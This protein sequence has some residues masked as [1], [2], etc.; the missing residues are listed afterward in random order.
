MTQPDELQPI[1]AGLVKQMNSLASVIDTTVK[2]HGFA[3]LVFPLGHPGRVNYIS[4]AK[5]EDMIACMKE[6]I[7]RNEAEPYDA[8]IPESDLP[9]YAEAVALVRSEN[10]ASTSFIQRKLNIGYN[11]ACDLIDEMERR[12]VVSGPNHVGKREVLKAS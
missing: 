9:R 8:A 4:N 3:L 7:A 10:K 5:R 2:P 6:F 1:V 11:L 12:G